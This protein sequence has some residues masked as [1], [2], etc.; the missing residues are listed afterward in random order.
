MVET[1]PTGARTHTVGREWGWFFSAFLGIGLLLA[2]SLYANQREIDALERDRL[3]VQAKVVADNLGRQLEG[4]NNALEGVRDEILLLNPTSPAQTVSPRLKALNDAMPG[5]RSMHVLDA[6][7]RVTATSR[8][9]ATVGR[10]FA[11]RELFT[12]P[13]ERPDAT[14]LYV[15]PPYTSRREQVFTVNMGRALVDAKGAFTGVVTAA[16]DPEYFEVLLGSVLYAPDMRTALLHGDGTLF[17]YVPPTERGTGV[18]RS[19]RSS[20][21]TRHRDSGQ[22]ESVLVGTSTSSGNNR[23]MVMRTIRRGGP[24]MDRPLIVAVSRETAAIYLPWRREAALRGGLYLLFGTAAGLALYLKQRRQQRLERLALAQESERSEIAQRLELALAGAD[25]GLWDWQLPSGDVVFDQRWCTM[26]GYELGEIE[27]AFESWRRLVHPDDLPKVQAALAAHL[28]GDTPL[29]EFEHRLRHKGGEWRWILTRG[30]V[31]QRDESGKPVRVVGTHM[32][33]SARKGADVALHEAHVFAQQVIAS[34]PHGFAV[35]DAELRYRHWNPVMEQLTGLPA[36]RVIGRKSAE[37]LADLAPPLL[38]ALVQSLQRAL[39]GEIVVSA[40]RFIERPDRVYWTTAIHGPLR[41]SA[42][43]VIGTISSVQD[44]TDRKLAEQQLQRSEEDLAVTLQSIGDA[45]IATDAA[46]QI[47]RMNSS[48]ERLTGW[49]LKAAKGRPPRGSLSHRQ[50][51]DA[52][53]GSEPGASGARTRRDRRPGHPHCADL[54][55]RRRVPDCRHCCPYPRRE[56]KHHRRGLG[57]QR[58]HRTVPDA[59][60]AEGQRATLSHHLRGGSAMH[61]DPGWPGAI[62]RRE[63]CRAGGL[64]GGVDARSAAAPAARLGASRVPRCS[65]RPAAPRVDGRERRTG[66]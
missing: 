44:I 45:V 53:D 61:Q 13:R 1:I 9:P 5:I 34:L 6:Q 10:S 30:K 58:R 65:Q 38:D 50:R 36:E 29:Y 20:F 59:T 23:L 12:I 51:R 16:L 35:R 28:K 47:A 63:R 54:R 15:S 56:R 8:E 55:Q 21:F 60:G 25:L 22:V 46:G 26:L 19:K 49:T 32:D 57:V 40:D 66:I 42:G 11:E 24:Q 33:I 39:A 17:L 41:D 43:K 14:T 3:R 27:P 64:R 7:G 62:R 52:A 4:V 2:Y 37:V 48:A 18:D 31:V